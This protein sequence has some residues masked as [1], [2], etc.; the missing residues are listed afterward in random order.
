MPPE[1]NNEE[2]ENVHQNVI[3]ENH[4][5]ITDHSTKEW[6]NDLPRK[7]LNIMHLNIRSLRNKTTELSLLAQRAKANVIAITETWLDSSITDSEVMIPGYNIVRKD[8]STLGGG[9]CLY[10]KDT[11]AYNTRTDLSD[12]QFEAIWI[13]LLSKKTKPIL[14]GCVYR[15][16]HQHD[17]VEKLDETLA[18]TAPHMETVILGDMN[19]NFTTNNNCLLNRQYNSFLKTNGLTQLISDPTRISA[20]CSSVIDHILVSD[21]SIISKYGVISV[22]I[23][24]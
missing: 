17:F 10:V 18:K 7:G 14:I 11:L 21:K 2:A 3:S 4:P 16:P 6:T 23:S 24:E 15:P 9:V 8:R 19:I 20:Q 22:G 1:G 13:N 12:D 5:Q